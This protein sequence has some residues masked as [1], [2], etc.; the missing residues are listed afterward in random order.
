M[1]CHNVELPSEHPDTE[2]KPERLKV[3]KHCR[4]EKKVSIKRERKEKDT[5]RE[6]EPG[7]LPV[8]RG[9]EATPQMRPWPS[10]PVH[11]GKWGEGDW[12]LPHQA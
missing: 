9:N 6:K 12:G 2:K 1:Q 7:P 10:G 11:C 8:C 3:D 4:E 5:D